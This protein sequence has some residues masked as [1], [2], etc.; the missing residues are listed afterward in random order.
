MGVRSTI[1]EVCGGPEELTGGAVDST[2]EHSPNGEG[3]G[4]ESR[5]LR[6]LIVFSCVLDIIGNISPLTCEGIAGFLSNQ[7]ENHIW[8]H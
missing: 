8:K 5:Q 3:C 1:L 6:K 4:F 7:I 2:T